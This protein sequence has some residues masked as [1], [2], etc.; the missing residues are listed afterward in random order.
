MGSRGNHCLLSDSSSLTICLADHF[1]QWLKH[2]DIQSSRAWS[3]LKWI[4]SYH[5]FQDLLLDGEEREL[6]IA[7]YGW[8]E[9]KYWISV[10]KSIAKWDSLREGESVMLGRSINHC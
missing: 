5:I 1:S 9:G 6:G 7:G 2:R 10:K 3:G 4:S 8:P